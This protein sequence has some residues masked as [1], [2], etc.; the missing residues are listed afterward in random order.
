MLAATAAAALGAVWLAARRRAKDLSEWAVGGRSFGAVMVF[1]LFAGENFTT[2]TLLGAAGWAYDKGVAAVYS[3][4]YA[5]LACVLSYWYLPKIWRY[6]KE[7]RS[8]SQSDY[9]RSAYR[10]K[11]LGV[12]VTLV[13]VVAMVPYLALQLKGLAIIAH[14]TSHQRIS[15]EAGTIAGA[16]LIAAYAVLGGL[17]G[18]A[19]TSIVKDFVVIV[20]VLGVGVWLPYRLYGGW[21]GVTR[22]VAST[23]PEHLALWPDRGYGPVW[24][25]TTVLLCALGA[26]M[27]PHLFASFFSAKDERNLR[28]TLATAPFYGIALVTTMVIGFTAL[29]SLPPLGK[30]N[31]DLAFLRLAAA[32]LPD[33]ALG[34]VGATGL[35]TALIPGSVLAT[36]IAA[37]LARDGYANLRPDASEAGLA[38]A[39]KWLLPVAVAF[40]AVFALA[41]GKT[42]VGLLLAGYAIV[43]QVF[44]AVLSSVLPRSPLTR[45][46][47]V[48]GLLLGSALAT[49]APFV[50]GDWQHLRAF[51][52]EQ[53]AEVNVG[54]LALA[55]NVLV[56]V[57]VSAWTRARR[58]PE[59]AVAEQ[60]EA[61]RP[62]TV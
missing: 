29:V 40:A 56:A 6:A 44:P 10:S 17:R 9:L 24:F 49:A 12:I 22:A 57:A 51:L 34:F 5:P 50:G 2:F 18:A 47:V 8:V 43:V 59:P 16:A 41:G 55:A 26:H 11:A 19:L 35:L 23:H 53:L 61:I 60:T 30:G 21:G 1:V 20:V 28:R 27:W 54:V 15:I 14:E 3:S 31:E 32:E 42:I 39:A 25:S 13:G 37:S 62:T 4:C 36:A 7:H 38:R 58:P 52:P 46:G 48:A 45:E 33:P